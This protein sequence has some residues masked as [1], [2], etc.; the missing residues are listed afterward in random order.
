MG[1]VTSTQ[2]GASTAPNNLTRDEAADRA[3]LLVVSSNDVEL[4]LTDGSGAPGDGTFRS[5]ST[6]RFSCSEPGAQ[7]HL[8]L[9]AR[10]VRSILLNGLPVDPGTAFDGN[11]IELEGLLADNELVVDADAVYMRSGEGL[12]RFV[13]PVDGSVYLYSQFETFDAH[14][15][16]A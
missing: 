14:R 1:R 8:D 12:H 16:Y 5:R 3:R 2:K 4:D 15:M 9:T 6:I 7:V 13:D 11:R 10:T